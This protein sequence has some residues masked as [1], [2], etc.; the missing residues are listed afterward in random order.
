MQG[1]EG[2]TRRLV[3]D[4][5]PPQPGRCF[6]DALDVPDAADLGTPVLCILGEDNRVLPRP[7]T[8]FEA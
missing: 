5:L 8:E 4:L 1:V 3:A 2:S 6:L 7:G